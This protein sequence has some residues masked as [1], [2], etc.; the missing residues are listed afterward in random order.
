MILYDC[1]IDDTLEFDG[2]RLFYVKT[3]V[4][5]QEASG[6]GIQKECQEMQGK[7]RERSQVLQA[8]KGRASRSSRWEK[9]QVLQRTWG[10]P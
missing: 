4:G 9:L 7:I 6:A 10:S 3:G 5:A 2:M 8:N 1:E